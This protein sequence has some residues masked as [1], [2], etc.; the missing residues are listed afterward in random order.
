M[1]NPVTDK[2]QQLIEDFSFFE[3]NWEDKYQYIIDLGRTLPQMDENLKTE[4]NKVTGCQSQ[5]WYS[6]EY[7]DGKLYFVATSDAA[8][9]SGLIALL[10]FTF[11]GQRPQD[12]A[13]A[14]LD[15]IDKIGLNQH[16]SPMRSNGL[17]AM[18]K[19]IKEHAH[20]HLDASA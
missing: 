5:V 14:S 18:I 20:K 6:S 19:T 3:N 1:S 16:L 8:I 10:L 17:F 13:D 7:K 2:Q 4:E 12:I 11:S 9:V 15:F